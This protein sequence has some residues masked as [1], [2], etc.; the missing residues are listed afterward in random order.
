MTLLETF[1]GTVN[2]AVDTISNVTQSIIDRNKTNAKLNR[3]R[4]VMKNES[5]LMNRAYIELGKQYYEMQKAGNFEPTETQ[6]KLFTV[7]DGSKS[8][9]SRVRDKYRKIVEAE[10]EELF[11]APVTVENAQNDEI[12]DITVACSNESDYPTSPFEETVNKT[13]VTEEVFSEE[14]E[15]ANEETPKPEEIVVKEEVVKSESEPVEVDVT[16]LPKKTP[17]VKT[18]VKSAETAEKPVKTTRTRRTTTTR[19]TTKTAEKPV[20][21]DTESPEEELFW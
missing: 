8:K 12:V 17:A 15:T 10:N 18:T 9:L 16:P 7:I 20:I 2:T 1:K 21:V 19:K 14:I 5:E 13:E 4:L 3:L 11:T 6:K